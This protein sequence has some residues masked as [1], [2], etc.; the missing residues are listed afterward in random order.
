MNCIEITNLSVN[1]DNQLALKNVNLTIDSGQMIAIIGQNGSGKS[2]LIKAILGLIPAQF[3]KVLFFGQQLAQV[4][5]QITYIPQRE[6]IDWDFPISVYEVVEM[7]RLNPNKWWKKS[8]QM[9]KQLIHEALEKVGML[10]EASKQIGELSGGQQQRV[11]LARALVQNTSLLIMDEPFSGVDIR[12]QKVIFDVL[13][14]LKNAG[15]TMLIVHHDLSTVVAHF[16]HAIVLKNE[17][18]AFGETEKVFQSTII[19]KAFGI[20]L[21]LSKND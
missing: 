12:S 15:K 5:S 1:Y 2:T 14:D 10:S 11:F 3:E 9:D 20:P 17:L 4:R 21:N 13:T 19:E 18:L 6:S 8:D 16:D 7:G